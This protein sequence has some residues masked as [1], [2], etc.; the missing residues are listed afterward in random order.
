MGHRFLGQLELHRLD[1]FLRPFEEELLRSGRR[2]RF[3]ERSI[4]F[5]KY[6]LGLLLPGGRKSM[7]PI[8]QRTLIDED[9]LHHFITNAPWEHEGVQQR[10]LDV[11][12]N[13]ASNPQ[14]VIV[15]DDTGFPKQGEDSVGVQRQ[16]SGT[17]GK[18]GNC[19]VGVCA[20]YA[21]PDA[22]Y[23]PDI[24]AWPFGF[25]LYLPES[26]LTR[27]RR[28]ETEIPAGV[29]FRTKTEIALEFVERARVAGV[30]H[31]ATIGDAG[32]GD[33]SDFRGELRERGEAY[34]LGVNPSHLSVVLFDTPVRDSGRGHLMY[35]DQDAVRTPKEWAERLPRTAWVEMVWARGS[36]GPLR[37]RFARVRV[38]VVRPSDK[39][40]ATEE[41]GWLLLEQR[42]NELKAYLCWG[43]DDAS[44]ENLVQLAHA[45][46]IVEQGFRQMKGELGLDHFEGRSYPGWH[47][48]VTLVMVAYC[49][50][51]WLRIE[52]KVKDTRWN[53]HGKRPTFEQIRQVW[54]EAWLFQQ[55][56]KDGI[57]EGKAR[58]IAERLALQVAG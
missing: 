40:R 1:G 32:F 11:M 24:V 2:G 21:V 26:W 36:K 20:F 50:I 23:N 8:A 44:L 13:V 48:H 34:V 9:K 42:S 38:R 29:Q 12:K 58:R 30:P 18:V 54:T 51:A 35:D 3:Q 53:H 19:Q 17:L 16:Y 27:A 55:F 43:F 45:R 52:G 10:I 25:T 31:A 57:P 41:T 7:Q 47:H 5:N 15:L 14:G 4:S 39:F 49:Y 46:W 37:G 33:S 28:K 56:K 6:V 22:S